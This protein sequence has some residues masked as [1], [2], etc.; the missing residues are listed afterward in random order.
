MCCPQ[1]QFSAHKLVQTSWKRVPAGDGEGGGDRPDAFC[2]VHRERKRL[3]QAAGP[4]G[5]KHAA[6]GE[7]EAHL[8]YKI[9][10]CCN[11]KCSATHFMHN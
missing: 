8:V 10:I 11:W 9:F 4:S 2:K 7:T 3:E 5:R 6:Q 1:A